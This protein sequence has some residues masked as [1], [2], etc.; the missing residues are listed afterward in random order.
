MSDIV[1]LS[2]FDESRV[3]KEG[4]QNFRENAAYSWQWLVSH[5]KE[6]NLLI[7]DLNQYRGDLNTIVKYYLLE[8][9]D[10]NGINK[11]IL[12]LDKV[13]NTRDVD[14][15][16]LSA[17]KL[18][19]AR[20]INGVAF[21]GSSN[22]TVSDS[23]AV[24]L[25]GNQTVAGIKTFS[26]SPIVPTPTTGTQVANKAYVDSPSGG[27]WSANDTRAKTA[28]NAGG[29]APIY[30]CRAWVNFNGVGTVAIRASGNVSSI[31]DNGVG[32]Y[33]VNFTTAMPDVKYSMS[34]ICNGFNLDTSIRDLHR[35]S[36][37]IDVRYSSS[38]INHKHD[39]D[40]VVASVFR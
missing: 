39:T 33:T 16:V 34:S 23:T 25:T 14:K 26:S 12:E 3:A 2:P 1:K 10:E 27:A 40:I 29:A 24:K 17:T 5:T 13:D 21:D 18:A 28:L 20:T 35:N 11:A 19:T 7:N 9:L 22:I 37:V 31:T 36:A 15:I 6:V 38:D 4:T 32:D 8:N 30:A